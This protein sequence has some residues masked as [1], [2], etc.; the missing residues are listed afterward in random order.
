MRWEIG[1]T[2]AQREATDFIKS[3]LQGSKKGIGRQLK[4]CLRVISVINGKFGVGIYNLK[5]SHLHWYLS[6]YDKDHSPK[7]RNNHW[8]AVLR[9][10][11]ALG[12]EA[13]WKPRLSSGP[14]VRKNGDY[15]KPIEIRRPSKKATPSFRGR[16]QTTPTATHKNR[17]RR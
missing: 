9:I 10:I 4:E 14:W 2:R 15:S 12:K 16:R 3:R 7:T 17:K 1:P 11:E 13:D 5:C 6:V 8:Y